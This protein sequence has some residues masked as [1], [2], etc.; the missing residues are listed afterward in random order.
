MRAERAAPGRDPANTGLVCPLSWYEF[1][2]YGKLA[3]GVGTFTG[4]LDYVGGA[5]SSGTLLP[6]PTGGVA[7]SGFQPGAMYNNGPITL[8]AS[9]FFLT[10]Q[11]SAALVGISQRQETGFA[12][13]GNY[14][15]APGL[16]LVAEYQY[17]YRHQGGFNFVTNA[18]GATVDAKS[19]TYF[20]GAVVTW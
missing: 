7:E 3:T 6:R 5:I 15:V 9:G 11:G 20:F 12:I 16:Y 1:A 17:E 2:V 18:V 13:G 8:G 10:S 19:N 4:S 14:N